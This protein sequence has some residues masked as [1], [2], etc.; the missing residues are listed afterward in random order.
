[1]TGY[2]IYY[3][4]GSRDVGSGATEF[5]LQGGTYTITMVALS[6]HLPSDPVTVTVTGEVPQLLYNTREATK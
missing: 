4:G 5:T 1:M 2:K 6:Q 3:I